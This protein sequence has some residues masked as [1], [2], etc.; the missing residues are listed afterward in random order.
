ML[1]SKSIL[2]FGGGLLAGVV[3]GWFI[4]YPPVDS[5]SAAGWAQAL[6]SIAAIVG[7]FA[8]ATR[9]ATAQHRSASVLEK[10]ALQRRWLS[11]KAILDSI[12]Q[13]CLDVEQAF[14]GDDD[15]EALD[16]VGAH[17]HKSF[18]GGIERINSIPLFD[19]DSDVLVTAVIGLKEEATMLSGFIEEGCERRFGR[20]NYEASDLDVKNAARNIIRHIKK[21]YAEAVSVTGGVPITQARSMFWRY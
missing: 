16:F 5:A 11:V 20:A 21:Y 3:I 10:E 14:S 1:N 7:A 2:L 13:Q 17:D 12:Y 18:L 4:E 8:V 6:G 15:F 9:Q 19:L